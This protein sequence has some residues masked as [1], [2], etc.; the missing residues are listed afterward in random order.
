MTSATN[1][2]VRLLALIALAALGF[3]VFDYIE[4]RGDEGQLDADYRAPAANPP[5]EPDRP[6]LFEEPMIDE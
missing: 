3:V 6:D 2:S 1:R 5:V 4:D